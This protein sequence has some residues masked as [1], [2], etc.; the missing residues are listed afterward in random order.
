VFDLDETLVRV[1]KEEPQMQY[2]TRIN[3][4]DHASNHSYFVSNTNLKEFPG[5]FQD[6]V[7]KTF[8]KKT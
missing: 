2:D 3:V 5:S 6:E 7:I 4:V 8:G 1:Q